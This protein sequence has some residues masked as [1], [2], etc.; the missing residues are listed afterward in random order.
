MTYCDLHHRSIQFPRLCFLSCFN[1][2]FLMWCLFWLTDISMDPA[3]SCHSQ[4]LSSLNNSRTWAAPHIPCWPV[5]SRRAGGHRLICGSIQLSLQFQ[6]L[7]QMTSAICQIAASAKLLKPKL[8]SLWP[9]FSRPF[10][11]MPPPSCRGILSNL[12]RCCSASPERRS[13]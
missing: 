8:I 4:Q 11:V 12:S 2:V 10:A 3:M 5:G 1:D 7:L 6:Y 9:S 13:S